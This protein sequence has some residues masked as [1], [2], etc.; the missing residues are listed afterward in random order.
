MG[1]GVATA[2]KFVH[3]MQTYQQNGSIVSALKIAGSI[4]LPSRDAEIESVKI[5]LR[6]HT[7]DTPRRKEGEME[8]HNL[9]NTILNHPR[10]KRDPLSSFL[11]ESTFS[12]NILQNQHFETE[13]TFVIWK[14]S[15]GTGTGT[16]VFWKVST[17]TTTCAGPTW[18]CLPIWTEREEYL[19]LSSNVM[20]VKFVSSFGK[21][22]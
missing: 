14:V 7:S 11:S 2:L 15:T 10:Q 12:T 17:G 19:K 18:I 8:S 13:L 4:T 1:T 3:I 5:E 9:S 20:V 16:T 6:W 21:V 22:K